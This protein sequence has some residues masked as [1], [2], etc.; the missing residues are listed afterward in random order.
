MRGRAKIVGL[1]IVGQVRRAG[2]VGRG[3]IV[4]LLLAAAIAT[5]PVAARQKGG[6]DETGPYDVV[7]N[8][9]A[10]VQP[11]WIVFAVDVFAESPNRIF[12]GSTGTSPMPDAAQGGR[13]ASALRLF[14]LSI[15]GARLDHFLV[16]VDRQGRPIEEW[17]QWYGHFRVPHR[18]TM[19]PYDPERHVW[20][21]DRGSQQIF[22]FSNDGK[23]LVM[24]LGEKDVA[25]SD[26]TH[27]GRPTDIAFLPDGTFFVSDGYDNARVVKFDKNGKY[28]T[29]WGTKGTGPGQFDLPHCIAVDARRRVYVA[30]RSN[31]RIQVFD[32]NG[33]FL[34]EWRNIPQPHH[35]VITQEQFLWL[36]DGTTSR[37][38]KY[39]LN[40]KLQTYWGTQGT[41]P[42]YMNQPHA[43][44]VDSEGNLYIANGLN[45]R[46]EK[47]I[48]AANADRSRLVG[49]AFGPA[50]PR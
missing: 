31:H 12:I 21:V 20:F 16:V 44:S 18:I 7:E 23:R 42:G 10:P 50:A 43:F 8:W 14:N 25:G 48:P 5:L 13:G 37:I 11:G 47:Y 41:N 26:A 28:L 30:D 45:Q 19:D 3:G 1:L 6:E 32:E 4:I 15:P 34:D 39:D 36:S 49:Q 17:S 33:R 2:H 35:M 38:A 46:V 9:M 24:T 22:K 40:G 27:F 29:A